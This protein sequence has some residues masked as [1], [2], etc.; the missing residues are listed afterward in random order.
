MDL[1]KFVKSMVEKDKINQFFA[2]ALHGLLMIDFTRELQEL[3]VNK[4]YIQVK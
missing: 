1:P 4:R 3:N 2:K